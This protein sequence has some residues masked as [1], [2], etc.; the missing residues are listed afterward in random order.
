MQKLKTSVNL[1][2]GKCSLTHFTIL[3]SLKR[4]RHTIV[5]TCST[6]PTGPLNTLPETC[7]WSLKARYWSSPDDEKDVKNTDVCFDRGNQKI[8][9]QISRNRQQKNGEDKY[10]CNS[11]STCVI[12][13]AIQASQCTPDV[14][15][16]QSFHWK[17]KRL[18]T[19]H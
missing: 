3:P 15:S 9:R 19:I 6:D 2:R 7:K 13:A 18:A 1:S 16:F 5:N 8:S 4:T 12:L 14:L 10:A 11:S 17:L